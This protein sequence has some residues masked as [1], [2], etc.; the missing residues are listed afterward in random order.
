MLD[1]A[2]RRMKSKAGEL[3]D[4][5]RKD[6]RGKF[7]DA[8]TRSF[9]DYWDHDLRYKI[10]ACK[11][12]KKPHSLNVWIEMEYEQMMEVPISLLN[13]FVFVLVEIGTSEIPRGAL[14]NFLVN[15]SID[16]NILKL[17]LIK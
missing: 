4:S 8:Q 6:R 17:I 13:I 9:S 14:A 7:K 5:L 12:I 15:R 2:W 16:G 11:P 3:Y 1:N 10:R